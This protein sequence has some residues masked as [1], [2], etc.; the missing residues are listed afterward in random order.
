MREHV[1]Q[2]AVS[3]M[4]ALSILMYAADHASIKDNPIS[5]RKLGEALIGNTVF[6]RVMT[7]EGFRQAR[8]R[9]E[10]YGFATMRTTNEGTVISLQ[11]HGFADFAPL[12][13]TN[14]TTNEQQ[15]N[16][17]PTTTKEEGKKVRKEKYTP[18]T[19][20][21]VLEE[22]WREY[23]QTRTKLKAP[24]SPRAINT[25]TNK[26]AKFA[27][28]GLQPN[29]LIETANAHG[30]KSVYPPA[31]DAKSR[32]PTPRE[33]AAALAT[34][35]DSSSLFDATTDLQGPIHQGGREYP[36][37]HE[38]LEL[39]AQGDTGSCHHGSGGGSDELSPQLPAAN[40]GVYESD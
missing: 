27:I 35:S 28:E 29:E 22:S 26:L 9:I 30:W 10:K 14:P 25:L 23:L 36:R 16:N 15:T 39:H 6:K 20:P 1:S 19:P 8:K 33:L 24:N 2:L 5:G 17:K 38:T 31:S 37:R 11:G 4:N 3:D 34:G 12:T 32:N 13:T 7:P 40:R 21:G 18:P